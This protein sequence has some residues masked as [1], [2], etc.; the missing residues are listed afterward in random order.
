V[1]PIIAR[2]L[3]I[4]PNE[5]FESAR[6]LFDALSTSLERRRITASLHHSG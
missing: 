2:A 6:Q 1:E 3:A 4:K 5:R